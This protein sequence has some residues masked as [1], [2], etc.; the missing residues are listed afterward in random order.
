MSKILCFLIALV[1]GFTLQAQPK[2]TALEITPA[3]P[4]AGGKVSFTYNKSYGPLVK[5]NTLDVIVY[6]INGSNYKL[7]EPTLTVKSNLY[8]GTVLVDNETTALLFTFSA[9]KMKD[10]EKNKGYIVPVYDKN[11]QPVKGYYL[12]ASYLKG[13]MGKFL[14]D[15]DSDAQAALDILDEGMKKFPELKMDNNFF[16]AYLN[17]TN[18]VLKKDANPIILTKLQTFAAAP[19][20]TEEQYGTLAQWYTRLKDK[21][22]AEKYRTLQKEKFPEGKWRINEAAMAVGKEKDAA[23]KEALVAEFKTK[24]GSDKA[25]AGFI[26]NLQSQVAMAYSAEKNYEQLKKYAAQLSPEARAALY[27]N[28]SWNMAEKDEAMETAEEMSKVAYNFAK[29]EAKS[30]TQEKPENISKK[31]WQEERERNE[32]MYGDT[33]AFILYKIGDH[34]TAYPI[35]K[36]A[37]IFNKLKD[38]E[39]NERYA[40]LATEVLTAAE[41]QKIIEPMVKEGAASDKTK[42]SL[43]SIYLKIN[44]SDAGYDKYL[45]ALEEEAKIKKRA[46]IAATIINEKAP[47]FKLK[48]FDG[49]Y[50]SLNDMKGKIVILDFW[51]TW[52]GPCIAS[53]PGMNKAI[54]K[55]KDRDDV[56]FLFVDTWENV[57]NKL[58]NAKTFMEKKGYPFHV[59]MDT[60]DKVVADY[61]VSGIPTKF[62]IDKQG[63]IRFKA[64]GFS[65]T[66]EGV[67][68]EITAMIELSE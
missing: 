45:S 8:S 24:Y 37:A 7:T 18:T 57:E 4:A 21:E 51:A 30:P 29:A 55:F 58:D 2:F 25:N 12:S 53:M 27:N 60:E 64:I 47:D 5:E 11:K 34:K 65:G 38:A 10:N 44:K 41:A 49:N 67:I 17:N 54:S 31:Q 40:L 15:I 35:A 50:V 62:I 22:N 20:L 14:A 16:N 66:D 9:D 19:N 68:E 28:L 39:Y 43:K 33:Y 36:S 56:K 23:K 48:D 26:K 63:N 52:C 3:Y 6:Q 46:E 61:G 59:I 42:E 13:G 1:S 32:A